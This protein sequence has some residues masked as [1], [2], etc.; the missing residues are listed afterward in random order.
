[1]YSHHMWRRCFG[2]LCTFT[3]DWYYGYGYPFDVA[4]GIGVFHGHRFHNFH[5]FAFVRGFHG[6]LTSACRV[7]HCRDARLHGWFAIRASF[8]AGFR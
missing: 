3:D 5:H 7:V 8:F 1:M 2:A 6:P 4:F